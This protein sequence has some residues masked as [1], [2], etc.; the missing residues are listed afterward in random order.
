MPWFERPSARSASTSR[1]RSMSSSRRSVRRRLP[2][3]RETMV[4][5]T[6]ERR[7]V[8]YASCSETLGR[9]QRSFLAFDGILRAS[10]Y[11]LAQPPLAGRSAGA[12]DDPELVGI[13]HLDAV[14]EGR[15][16]FADDVQ[17]AEALPG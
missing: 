10:V 7:G 3:S 16:E 12:A 1:S 17:V 9:F 13:R 8:P 14:D 11:R 5:M 4:G 6:P 2:R 15:M